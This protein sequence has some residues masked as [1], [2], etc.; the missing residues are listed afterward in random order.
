MQTYPLGSYKANTQYPVKT[1]F[2]DMIEMF[3]TEKCRYTLSIFYKA[4]TQNS[5]RT[6]FFYM[7]EL[8]VMER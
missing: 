6:L 1:L 8:F 4:N 3:I 5:V 7:I 2:I